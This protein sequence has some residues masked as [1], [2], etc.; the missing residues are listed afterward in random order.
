MRLEGRRIKFRMLLLWVHEHDENHERKNL[1]EEAHQYFDNTVFFLE[2]FQSDDM[3]FLAFF[4]KH[5]MAITLVAM[6]IVS[7]CLIRFC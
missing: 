7:K 4:R 6:Q 1:D 3:P 5:D 2:I